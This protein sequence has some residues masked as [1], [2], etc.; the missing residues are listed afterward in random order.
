MGK[1]KHESIRWLVVYK[2][3]ILGLPHDIVTEH[4]DVAKKTQMRILQLYD[5]T[6]EVASLQGKRGVTRAS[7]AMDLLVL[8]QVMDSPTMYLREHQALIEL[9]TGEKVGLSSLCSELFFDETSKKNHD[10]RRLLLDVL[11]FCVQSQ[12]VLRPHDS[13]LAACRDFSFSVR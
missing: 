4:L 7:E 10:M 2:R 11:V 3:L 8:E 9:S 5:A 12:L 13:V 1:A 6:G